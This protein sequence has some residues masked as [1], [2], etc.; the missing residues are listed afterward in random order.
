MAEFKT[1]S[2]RVHPETHSMYR[3]I[4]EFHD[5]KG[6]KVWAWWEQ[7]ILREYE[8]VNKERKKGA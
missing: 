7:M 6:L 4:A 1:I 5:A 3:D 2:V 8:R